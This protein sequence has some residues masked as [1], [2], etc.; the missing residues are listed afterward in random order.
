MKIFRLQQNVR[1]SKAVTYNGTAYLSAQVADDPTAD[2]KGQ[3]VQ[4]LARIEEQLAAIGSSKEQILSAT[5]YMD[6]YRKW[7]AFNEVWDA[8]V[9]ADAKPARTCVEAKLA[10]PQ[11]EVEISVIAACAM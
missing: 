7:G 1:M 11:Y 3:V 2:F 10:F 8:W 4:I 5:A 9:P 6:D